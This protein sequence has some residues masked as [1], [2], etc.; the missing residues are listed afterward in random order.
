MYDAICDI[1]SKLFQISVNNIF[2]LVAPLIMFMCETLTVLEIFF[3]FN[4][5]KKLI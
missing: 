4:T 2:K 1:T 3:V 5:Y